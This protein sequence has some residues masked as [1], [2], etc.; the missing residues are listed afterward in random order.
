MKI[1]TSLTRDDVLTAGQLAGVRFERLKESG[2]RTHPRKFDLILSGSGTHGGQFGGDY[3]TATW[4]EWG[5]FLNLIFNADPEARA[6]EYYADRGDFRWKTSRRFDTLTPAE[7]HRRHRWVRGEDYSQGCACGAVRRWDP[8][9]QTTGSGPVRPRFERPTP[10]LAA[11][12]A[13]SPDAMP[14]DAIFPPGIGSRYESAGR[15]E[16]DLRADPGDRDTD[17]LLIEIGE[18]V[19]E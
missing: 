10:L 11:L 18:L 2:S 19:D 9:R 8:P 17:A 13:A 14:L 5:I 3:Q 12:N 16:R 15:Y 1:H 4:D 7:Q 6:G